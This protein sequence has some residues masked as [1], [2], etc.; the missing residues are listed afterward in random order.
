M[1]NHWNSLQCPIHEVKYY[2]IFTYYEAC[3]FHG[4]SCTP[5][6]YKC[7][8][9]LSE[10]VPSLIHW[11][12]QSKHKVDSLRCLFPEILIQSRGQRN[13]I[14]E[15]TAF[16]LFYGVTSSIFGCPHKFLTQSQDLEKSCYFPVLAVSQK[17]VLNFL[18]N[19]SLRNRRFL[20]LNQMHLPHRLGPYHHQ[21]TWSS[22]TCLDD[23]CKGLPWFDPHWLIKLLLSESLT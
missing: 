8:K 23:T 17:H 21:S 14:V 19:L 5:L 7:L 1:R 9:L 18:L 11:W 2:S 22:F 15:T 12:A 3:L 13:R 16:L 4:K 6:A 20:F 10:K